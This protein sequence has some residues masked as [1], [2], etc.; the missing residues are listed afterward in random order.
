MSTVHSLQS[1]QN[2]T[3]SPQWTRTNDLNIYSS[4]SYQTSWEIMNISANIRL[5]KSL[6]TEQNQHFFHFHWPTFSGRW[7]SLLDIL[8]FTQSFYNIK[9]PTG[10]FGCLRVENKRT[11]RIKITFQHLRNVIGV[12]FIFIF[13]DKS[14][15]SFDEQHKN[16]FNPDTGTMPRSHPQ[17][18]KM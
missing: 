16:H 17:T 8:M 6:E 1:K 15:D 10:S 12:L 7:S 5:N 18:V 9:N 4:F 14:F 3:T 13:F 11:A 2:G